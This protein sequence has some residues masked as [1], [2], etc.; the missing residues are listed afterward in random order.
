MLTVSMAT[1]V[2]S[3]QHDTSWDI[4][5]AKLSCKFRRIS[6]EEAVERF[7]IF[8]KKKN[9]TKANICSRPDHLKITTKSKLQDAGAESLHLT[10]D[11]WCGTK[12]EIGY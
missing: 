8:C 4:K 7:Q 1:A 9:L 3:L 12:Y 11:C 6:P 10:D 2:M 5:A